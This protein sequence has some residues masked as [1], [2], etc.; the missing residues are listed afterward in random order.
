MPPQHDAAL[1]EPVQLGSKASLTFV[2][3]TLGIDALGFGIVVPIVPSLVRYLTGDDPGAAAE[4]VGAL[5]ATFAAAQF[6]AAPVLG[7]LSDRFGRRPVI[8]LSL[9]GVAANYMLL[10][11]APS[12][13]WLF[14]GRLIAGATAA[15]A[16]AANAY[17]AD[18]TPPAL[19]S[20][21][22]GLIGA[23][24]GAG[25][26]FGPALGG[27]LGAIDLRLP[28]LVAGGLALANASFGALVLRESLT[29]ERRR[30]FS[31]RRANP[32]GSL[33][34]LAADRV[35]G[36]LA[37]G[38]SMLWFGLGAL[39]SAF[40]LSTA[41]RFGW[42]PRENGWA[43]AAVGISQA[44]VQ[45]LLVRPVIR[46]LGERRAAFVGFSLS[47]L[48]YACFGFAQ[49][50]W[51]IYAAVLLQACGAIATPAMRAML[52]L[53]AG[54]ERQGE[55]QGGLS[56]VEGLT[57]IVAPV[58]AAAIFAKAV[59]AGGAAWSGA[60]FLVGTLTY[61]MAMLT[62]VR[63]GAGLAEPRLPPTA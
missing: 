51:V 11:W 6:V 15:S 13:V 47:S 27:L 53:R 8:I 20:S 39:Q 21:R 57:A 23:T 9:L 33:H 59:Q 41:L 14:A 24:F 29:P 63:S 36:W 43:L 52:S 38:W 44:L 18:I 26:V 17:I 22:F 54:P 48:A 40:V 37:V 34:T 42:G 32:I 28:F 30:S 60:P 1:A 10:A 25:F 31:W 56:S 4:W 49:S 7:G 45:G 3:L 19:R 62:L 16:S 55:M 61:G 35:T 46:R 12:L 58:V 5:V 2:L 50:G